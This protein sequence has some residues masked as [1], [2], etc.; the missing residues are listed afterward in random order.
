[1]TIEGGEFSTLTSATPGTID[2]AEDDITGGDVIRIDITAYAGDNAAGL[3][4]HITF[5]RVT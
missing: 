3:E 1:M 5:E 4:V 2:A